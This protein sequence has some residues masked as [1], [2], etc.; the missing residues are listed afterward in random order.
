M[1]IQFKKH[2]RVICD[3]KEGDKVK[4]DGF[5]K[6]LDSKVSTVMEVTWGRTCESGFMV[7][8]DNYPDYL[9]SDWF[10]KVK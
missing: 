7:K 9:D 6:A 10:D 2:V 8:I 1:E 3:L 5:S 4:T